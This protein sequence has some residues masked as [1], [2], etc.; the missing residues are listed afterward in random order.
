MRIWKQSGRKS[1]RSPAPDGIGGQILNNCAIQLA[2]LFC[3]IFQLFVLLHKLSCPWKDSI[4]DS[5]PMIKIPKLLSDFRPVAL[6]NLGIKTL[7]VTK[8]CILGHD[9]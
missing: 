1:G 3:F 8:G 5:V 2:D 7:K 9:T 4:I 6:T